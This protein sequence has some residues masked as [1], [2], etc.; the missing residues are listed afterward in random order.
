MIK[1]KARFTYEQAQ[2][3]ID[4]KIKSQGD[5]PIGFGCVNEKDYSK[6]ANDIVIINELAKKLRKTRI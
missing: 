4:G 2:D 6:I 5:I 3:I 1:S